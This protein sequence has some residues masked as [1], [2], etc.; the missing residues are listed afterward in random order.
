ML[1]LGSYYIYKIGS[2]NAIYSWVIYSL[3]I[4]VNMHYGY[5]NSFLRGV[6]AIAESNKASLYTKLIQ[7]ACSV[8]LLLFGYGL[9]GVSI[10]FLVSGI[11]LRAYS[12]TVF[13][14]YEGIGTKLK[15]VQTGDIKEK[16]R[17]L[18]KIVWHNASKEG[19]ITLSNY[20]STQANTLICSSV[21]GL[22]STGSYGLSV[23]FAAII[24][25]LSS[26]PFQ[27]NHPKLQEMSISGN[28]ADG[29]KIF[30]F[31]MSLYTIIFIILSLF[32]ILCIPII[33]WLKPTYSIDTF[34]LICILV[35]MFIY[36]YY[37]LFC[38][39]ISTFN[40][41][42]YTRSFILT[43]L[44]SVAT[45]FIFAKYLHFGIWALIL[46]PLLVSLAYNA[47]KWPWYVFKKK[48]EMSPVQLYGIGTG[49]IIKYIKK[50]KI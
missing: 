1:S 21:L 20:L 48:L 12:Y 37:H 50:F 34:M 43:A 49:E 31:A 14:K 24:S 29:K 5:Y 40:T 11:F 32:L 3:A 9:I 42:P 30:S 15:S 26:V 45:S 6:G 46:C 38:S 41:L 17:D 39:Y 47:W 27:V 8:L 18:F 22:A 23:Q 35:Y 28:T 25:T 7:V 2:F 44:L 36:H 4:F 19:L 13:M 16:V 33:I 10:A